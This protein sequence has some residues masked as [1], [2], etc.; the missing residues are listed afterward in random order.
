MDAFTFKVLSVNPSTALPKYNMQFKKYLGDS[1]KFASITRDEPMQYAPGLRK[2]LMT[3]DAP[4]MDF[5]RNLPF[6][7]AGKKVWGVYAIVMEKHGHKPML[8]IGAGS[9]NT[10]A[11][12]TR[13]NNH[14][15]GTQRP[16]HI[17]EYLAEGYKILS[18][19]LLCWSPIL[20]NDHATV[21]RYRVYAL[22]ATFAF[23]F[24]AITEKI[25]DFLWDSTF[26]W[27]REEVEKSYGPLCSH[28]P[29]MNPVKEDIPMSAKDI[30][31]LT[32]RVNSKNA[33]ERL[34][35]EIDH[36]DWRIRDKA[37]RK[38]RLRQLKKSGRYCCKLW[39]FNGESR[40]ALQRHFESKI[41]Y[42]AVY[43]KDNGTEFAMSRH[44][45]PGIEKR[46]ADI[47]N[48]KYHCRQTMA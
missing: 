22:E 26:N 8:Y 2:V 3:K 33:K 1:E 47:E 31:S 37:L 20:R 36:E 32:D 44:A 29:L 16:K 19:G 15:N 38:K 11:V 40:G 43:V 7:P 21:A 46:E 13:W 41:H 25:H 28:T 18:K 42:D 14:D 9:N 24:K 27:T 30:Q 35:D 34:S 45:L 39:V 5:F 4:T 48:G 23:I 10:G 17:K 6:T 12:K